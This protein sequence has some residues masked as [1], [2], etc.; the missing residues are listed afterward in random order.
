MKVDLSRRGSH[1]YNLRV[2]PEI[3][4]SL[5]A[6]ARRN[7]KAISAGLVRPLFTSAIKSDV[8]EESV[9]GDAA[10]RIVGL[11]NGVEL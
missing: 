9:A 6:F 8:I 7:R 1:S 4:G 2:E 10:N 11:G 3:S 5:F